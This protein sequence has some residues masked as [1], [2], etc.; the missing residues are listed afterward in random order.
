MYFVLADLS[1]IDVMYQFSLDWFQAMFTAAISGVMSVKE[2][3]RMSTSGSVLVGTPRR[4]S[5]ARKGSTEKDPMSRRSSTEK[6]GVNKRSVISF[7]KTK[8]FFQS[9]TIKS[10]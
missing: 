5:V 7:L 2:H 10:F 3:R 8:L 9:R 1:G 6:E 4:S